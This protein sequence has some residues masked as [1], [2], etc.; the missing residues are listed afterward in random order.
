MSRLL[1]LLLLGCGGPAFICEPA[2]V[3]PR[4]LKVV[5]HV[6]LD[7]FLYAECYCDRADHES[8]FGYYEGADETM[9]ARFIAQWSQFCPAR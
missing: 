4:A 7:G 8:L 3:C 9:C 1:L 5:Q 2:A 6:E